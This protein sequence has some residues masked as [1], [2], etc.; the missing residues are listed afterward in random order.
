MYIV[1]VRCII[2]RLKGFFGPMPRTHSAAEITDF[3]DQLCE[4]AM[5]RFSAHGAVGLTMRTLAAD[6]G[7]SP[8][9][10]YRYFRDKDELVAAVRARA[11]DRFAATLEAAA[12]GAG[13][14]RARASAVGEAYVAFALV[15]REAYRLMFE[16]GPIDDAAFPDLAAAKARADRNM[17]GYVEAMIADGLLKGDPRTIGQMFW[18]AVHGVVLL[19]LTGLLTRGAGADTLRR[20][21]VRALFIGL[22]N[23]PRFTRAGS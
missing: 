18:A 21:I 13:E 8:M 6:V 3:R 20:E 4:A 19:E 22:N 5:R 9:K 2:S 16:S 23:D 12:A 11:F 1:Y 17:T 10:A 14:S 15:N 7:C